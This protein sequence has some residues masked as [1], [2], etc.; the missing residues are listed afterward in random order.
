MNQPHLRSPRRQSGISLI[1]IMIG[2]TIALIT[3]L[4][5]SQIMGLWWNQRKTTD[6]ASEGQNQG[7]TSMV[8]MEQAIRSAGYGTQIGTLINCSTRYAYIG[9]NGANGGEDPNFAG[10]A[11]GVSIAPLI[12]IDGGTNGEADQIEVRGGKGNLSF[13]LTTLSKT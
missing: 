13:G 5:L 1:E 4:M 3:T 12:I 2:L 6:S 7:L 10:A 9:T 8:L 11:F